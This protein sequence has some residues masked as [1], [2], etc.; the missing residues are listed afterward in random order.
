MTMDNDVQ[1][2]ER[3]SDNNPKIGQLGTHGSEVGLTMGN[4]KPS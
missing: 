3:K 1:K 4:G 2:L